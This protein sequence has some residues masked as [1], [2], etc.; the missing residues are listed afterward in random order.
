MN[1]GGKGYLRPY[2]GANGYFIDKENHKWEVY[3]MTRHNENLYLRWCI[4]GEDPGAS[5]TDEDG[6][7]IPFEKKK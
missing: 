4:D 3:K 2:D 6:I 1:Y 7:F 5:F